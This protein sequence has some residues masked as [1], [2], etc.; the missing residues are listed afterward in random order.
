M[1]DSGKESVC[2]SGK[3]SVCDSWNQSGKVEE[4]DSLW[5]NKCLENLV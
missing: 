4:G 2:D 5:K 1:R 3:E